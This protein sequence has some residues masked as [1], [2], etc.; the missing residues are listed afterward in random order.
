MIPL[1]FDRFNIRGPNGTH[2]CYVTIPARMSISEAKDESYNRLFQLDVS[3]ALAAQLAIAVEYVHSQ[4][5]VHGDFH[6]GYVLLQLQLG[7]PYIFSNI[8]LGPE[9]T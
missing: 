7:K 9:S 1:I 8:R 4:G 5:F 6:Y 3:R 2:A